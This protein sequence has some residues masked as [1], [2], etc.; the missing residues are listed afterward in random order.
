MAPPVAA[1]FRPGNHDRLDRTGASLMDHCA[2]QQMA[3]MFHLKNRWLWCTIVPFHL[4]DCSIDDC[5]D[6]C[7]R[8]LAAL[9]RLARCA[10]LFPDG[11][12]HVRLRPLRPGRLSRR[13][14]ARPWLA[15]HAGLR[16]QHLLVS[17]DLR[18]RH[19]HRRSARPYRAA[20][21]DPVRPL[22]A[23]RID[24][25][26]GADA[27]ALAALSCLCADGGRLDRHGHR[28]DRDGAELL[29]RSS[30]RP[31][32]QPRLQRRDLRRHRPRSAVAVADR[33]HRLPLGDAGAPRR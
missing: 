8:I 32:A 25:S 12:L 11:L 21:A 9:S 33:Q 2:L 6:E 1:V 18:P 15:G 19:L 28:G 3:T 14:S 24:R 27:D 4:A 31:R 5:R 10:G 20:F 7:R 29:V 16:G 26:A 13:A 23:R 30:P 17:A 22:G